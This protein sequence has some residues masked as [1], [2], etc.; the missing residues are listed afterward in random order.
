[1]SIK[2]LFIYGSAC[3]ILTVFFFSFKA[4]WQ[5]RFVH[6]DNNGL[7]TYSPDE[8]GNIFP[9]FSRVGYHETD[10]AI[11]DLPV[12][13]TIAAPANDTNC[14][15]QIQAAIAE[16]SAKPADAKGFRGALLL[17]KGIYK[18]NG[19]IHINQSGV[20]LRGEGDTRNGTVLIA[21]AKKQQ[22]LIV[23]SGTGNIKETPGSRIKITDSYVPVGSVSV[24]A[25]NASSFKPGDKIILYRPGTRKWIEDLKMDQMEERNGTKQWQPEEYNI[26]FERTVTKVDGNTISFDYPVV[27]AMET[28]YGGGEIY[29]YDFSGRISEVGIE[30][31]Y[32]ESTYASDTDE[33]HGWDAI[34]Y[35]KIH[36]G[37]LRNVTSRYFGYSLI[38]LENDARNITVTD[39]NCFDA[40]SIITGG[41]RYSFN[42]NGQFNLFMNCHATEGRHD[43]V[44]GAKVRGPNVF[45]NCTAEKTHADIGPHHRWA[46]GTLF[47]NIITD[48]EINIQDRGNWGSG[49][50]WSGVNQILWNCTAKTVTVQNPW[51][52]GNN[53]AIGL[54]GHKVQGRLQGRPDGVWEGYNQKN[55]EPASLYFA[56]LKARKKL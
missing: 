30:N 42:N 18:V 51:V 7:L 20:V 4:N 38:S 25:E 47:D 55:L 27:L 12:I 15:Q 5:S 32:C 39:C 1:M 17:K 28:K 52:N 54:K 44:T 43:Y 53:Y 6:I 33:Q 22:P 23:V 41:R 35:N 37:W 31:L 10:A 2:K 50:G 36:D 16:I 56:Q 13:K 24:H 21:T 14:L 9:D 29:K 48:G 3:L 40:K 11:P 26:Q 19:I 8:K 49:H 34:T 46:M 45:V